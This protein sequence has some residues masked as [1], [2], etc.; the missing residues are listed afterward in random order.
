MPDHCRGGQ[1]AGERQKACLRKPQ[2]NRR[3]SLLVTRCGGSPA[4]PAM[5]MPS[6]SSCSAPLTLGQKGWTVPA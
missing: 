5:V 4:E 1:K 6:N 2:E 3:R